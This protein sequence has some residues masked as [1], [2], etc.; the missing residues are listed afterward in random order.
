[1]NITVSFIISFPLTNDSRLRINNTYFYL[2][3]RL[4]YTFEHK[5]SVLVHQ[6]GATHFS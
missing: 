6:S 4:I 1:M 5:A 2:K 3:M